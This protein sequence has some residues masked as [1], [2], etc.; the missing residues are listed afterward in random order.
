MLTLVAT[1][2][3]LLQEGAAAVVLATAFTFAKLFPETLFLVMVLA[4][5]FTLHS[6][7][8]RLHHYRPPVPHVWDGV[9]E[10]VPAPK[11]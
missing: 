11:S 2:S 9:V 8:L 1:K 4:A 7:S 10:A 6:Y 3:S 5:A